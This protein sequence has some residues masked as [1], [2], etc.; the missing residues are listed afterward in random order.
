MDKYDV[1][2][3]Y[4]GYSAFRK[5]QKMLIDSILKGQD[6]LGIMSTG[7]GKSICYQVP[8]LKQA[9]DSK[10]A[11][12][13]SGESRR[14]YRAEARQKQGAGAN[15]YERYGERFLRVIEEYTG[16]MHEKFYFE[17]ADEL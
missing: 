6:V 17:E 4:F 10:A 2:K 8:A 3:Q 5:G 12:E 14:R 16:D 1:L 9:G 7:A 15:K 13:D 11:E